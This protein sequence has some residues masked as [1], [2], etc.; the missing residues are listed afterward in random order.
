VSRYRFPGLDQRSWRH[1]LAAIGI[2]LTGEL[3]AVGLLATG[4]WL[5]LSAALRPPILQLS[6]AIGAV[7]VLSL[8]RGTTRYAGQLVSHSVGLGLQAGLR[9]WLY[10]RLERL[11][12]GGL[13]GG[14]RG[15]LLARLISDTEEAQDVVVRA[16]VPVLA[17]FAAWSAA[18]TAV[19]I[20][21]PAGGLALLG[22][23][24]GA[25][26]GITAAAVLAGRNAAALPAARGA[27]GSWILGVLDS[28]EELAAA[29]AADWA[30]AQLA[31][32]ERA[33]GARTQAVAAA[34]GL[35]RASTA[36]AGGA[37]LA[38]VA[39]A[40]A[41]AQRS[42][43]ISP[44]ELG[45]LVFVALGV[46]G[47][48]QGLPDAVSRLPAGRASLQR[49]AGLSRLPDPVAAQ[50]EDGGGHER[51]TAPGPAPAWARRGTATVV[52]QGAALTYP[53]R[54]DPVLRGLDLELAPGRPVALAG[55]SG[56]GKSSVVF[57]LLRFIDLSAG[58]LTVDGTDARA[59]PPEQVRRLIA[60]SPEQPALFPA[61]LRANLRVGAPHAAD[62]QITGL[63]GR[64]GLGPWLNQLDL[65]LD[66]VIAP[67]GQPVSG[68]ELQRLSVARALLANRPVLLLDEPTGHLDP[69][70]ADAVLETVLEHAVDRSLLW[71]THSN[72]ELSVFPQVRSLVPAREG[73]WRAGG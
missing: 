65:G 11:V 8:L 48:L 36:L 29:A 53:H 71:V 40:G 18:V 30:L 22:A 15:D 70:A 33:L 2:A 13:P 61:T 31:A 41:A 42:G 1:L 23:G 64:L 46:A 38:G 20:L 24:A 39:W 9:T 35:G 52:L 51:A 12:P 54:Q 43:R 21:L 3:A 26:A 34:A 28:R 14:D 67:W 72:A 55:P 49:L 57:A 10:R 7:Q 56:S 73:R 62:E 17:A 68:G 50:A 59:L 37:G 44:V 5:L 60:W 69:A 63:L 4:G 47:L 27:V 45:V 25:A 66:T 19:A 58:R 16:A 32:R 6:V